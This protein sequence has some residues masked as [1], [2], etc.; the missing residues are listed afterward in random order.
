M[1]GRK[2]LAAGMAIMLA[3]G[4]FS[5]SAAMA[6]NA[7]SIDMTDNNDAAWAGIAMVNDDTVDTGVN[8]RSAAGENSSVEGFLY[9]GGAVR[10]L[11]KGDTWTEV[12]SGGITGYVK[13]EF[14]VYGAEAKGLAEYYGSYG[15]KASW[16]DVHAFSGQSGMS[17]I[18]DTAGDGDTYKLVAKDGDWMAVQAGR[19]SVA[20][21]PAED[22]NVVMMLNTAVAVGGEAPE[23]VTESFRQIEDTGNTE[24]ADVIAESNDSSASFGSGSYYSSNDSYTESY[25]DG[26]TESYDD[27]YTES[28]D[29]GYTESYDDG[30]T[31]S[32]DDGYTESYDDSYTESY[33]DS[34]STPS[35][36]PVN[37]SG[38]AQELAAQASSL[39]QEY[40]T[41][42]AAADAAV[43]NGSG[44]QAIKDTAA[45][46]VAAYARYVEA[47]NAADAAAW[48]YTAD[49]SSSAGSASSA[50]TSSASTASYSQSQESAAETTQAEQ[51]TAETT[52][53]PV[54]AS[55]SDLELLAALIYCEAG[56]QPY[57]G[58][59]A[60]G[61]VV[62][63]RIASGAFPNSIRE[64]IYQSGQFTPAY[65]GALA[66]ALANGSGAGYVGAASDALAGSD[67]TGGALYFNVHQGSGKKIGAHWFF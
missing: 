58:Q 26:Y 10:V 31:E 19:N 5:S 57:E 54:A 60:V 23:S 65:S 2:S 12:E 15:A 66:S 21:V 6:G 35:Y 53:S 16:D 20:Y 18:V 46:A 48:G 41:A 25:D 36:E 56:N 1:R 50:S 40:L 49:T 8:I 51:T 17:G 34:Y 47:Q 38:S 67:P 55:G 61:A 52:N 24:Y 42:Q 39:Y 30:Y 63:N 9:R 64:V 11:D 22:V 4:V 44:E 45:A 62:M 13:N 29:D 43:A 14:L 32:Y 28:Y 7:I 27:G 37:T 59:V 3:A 33:D